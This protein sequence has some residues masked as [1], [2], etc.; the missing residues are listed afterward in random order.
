MGA[1]I[2]TT[3]AVIMPFGI[4]ETTDMTSFTAMTIV[5]FNGIILWF[6]Y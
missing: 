1:L 5:G 3:K 4:F 6:D 2:V